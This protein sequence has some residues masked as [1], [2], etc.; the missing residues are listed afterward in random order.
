[1]QTRFH[2]AL[3][4]TVLI[5]S[6]AALA[7]EDATEQTGIASPITEPQLI[8]LHQ[9][10][11]HVSQKSPEQA[12]AQVL[13]M[14][15]NLVRSDYAQFF[16]DLQLTES[17]IDTV[18]QL[19]AEH[20]TLSSGWSTVGFNFM[21]QEADHQRAREALAQIEHF[22]GPAGFQEFQ[23]YQN[24]LP[25]RYQLKRL[26]R[27][28]IAVGHALTNEQSAQLVSIMKGE[29]E[30]LQSVSTRDRDEFDRRIKPRFATVLS[31]EQREF[32]EQY[33][34][35]RAERRHNPLSSHLA[36]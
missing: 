36:E 8:L 7:A 2:L 3:C 29:R 26:V 5:S 32:A 11:R 33:F 20:R 24:T 23:E 18:T 12:R 21:P 31:A 17:Q 9:P 19:I 6:R 22:L 4:A 13:A 25:E 35:G 15:S 27:L 28:L 30:L 10:P 1:M 34:A 16:A 14:Q